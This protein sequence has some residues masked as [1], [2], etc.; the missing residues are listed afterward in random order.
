VRLVTWHPRGIFDDQ[1][2]DKIVEFIE[3]EER[4]MDE[5]FNRFTDLDGLSEIHLKIGQ[6]FTIA[7]RRRTGY[8]GDPVK[9]VFFSERVVGFGIAHMIEAL[10]KDAQIRV[11]AFRSREAAA[12]WLGVPLELLQ[13]PLLSP[14]PEEQVNR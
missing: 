8:R 5:P 13:P 7:E 9:S 4:V 3:D 11:R 12:D 2:A 6:A 1:L 10:M 14:D